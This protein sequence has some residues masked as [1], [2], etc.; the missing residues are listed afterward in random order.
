MG[1]SDSGVKSMIRALSFTWGQSFRDRDTRSVL[2]KLLMAA[3]TCELALARDGEG[4]GKGKG[5][6]RRKFFG[7]S[8]M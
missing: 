8:P 1:E 2:E 7:S 6:G 5:E 3:H 4:E